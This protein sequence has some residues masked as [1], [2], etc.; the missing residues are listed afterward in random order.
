MNAKEL[1]KYGSV[2]AAGALTVMGVIG[3]M[4]IVG[5]SSNTATSSNQTELVPI[6]SAQPAGDEGNLDPQTSDAPA[7]EAN[8]SSTATSD[9]LGGQRD[10]T[11]PSSNTTDI[12]DLVRGTMVTIE[13]TV[14]RATEEDEF[15]IED[16]TGSVQVFTG[17]TFFTVDPGQQVTVVGLVD[18]GPF[19][20]IYAEQIVL[21]DGTVVSI[22][23]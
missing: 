4:T 18:D 12:R 23:Y 1:L 5:F 15:L 7:T 8:E 3:F 2:F 19:I 10:S 21:P 13:G 6:Q 9:A 11:P 14:T 17:R 16:S 22:S 20:E